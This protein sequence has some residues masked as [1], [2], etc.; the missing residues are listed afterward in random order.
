M[1]F[2]YNHTII[3]CF[4]GYVTQAIVNNFAPLLF[5]IFN[6]QLNVS[7]S[8]ITL[9]VT[10]NFLVQLAVDFIAPFFVDKIGYKTSIVSAHIFSGLGLLMLGILPKFL[11]PFPSLLSSVVIYAIGGGLIEVLVSP[12]VESCPS[13]NKASAMSLL[14]SFYSWGTMG[15]VILSTLFLSIFGKGTWH[16]LACIWA[17]LPLLNALFFFFVPVPSPNEETPSMSFEELFSEK[18]FFIFIV[19]MLSAGACE[20]SMSQWAS[21]FTEKALG[22][23]KSVGD[24][25]GITVFALMMGLARLAHSR[26]GDKISIKKAL[27]MSGL[28]STA[29]YLGVSLSHSAVLSLIFCALCGLSAGILWPGV[30]SLAAERFPRGGTL[31]F[32]YLALAGDLGCSMGP[33]LT[34][35]VSSHF[36]GSLKIGLGFSALFPLLLVISALCLKSKKTP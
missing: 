16:I 26:V 13:D 23:S 9:L 8:N 3:A 10:V 17:L 32:A 6:S 31:M 21:F 25:L 29:S 18:T 33:T 11:P 2:N 27:V 5:V 1:K 20:Q 28:L 34:G 7:L 12:I 30:F 19:L 36:N 22:V 15:V 14:H 24:L 4:I 35:F